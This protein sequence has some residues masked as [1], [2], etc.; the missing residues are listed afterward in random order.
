MKSW[1]AVAVLALASSL[2]AQA[3]VQWES[4]GLPYVMPPK[5]NP[6]VSDPDRGVEMIKERQVQ[7]RGLTMEF[8]RIGHVEIEVFNNT[9]DVPQTEAWVEVDEIRVISGFAKVTRSKGLR[10]FYIQGNGPVVLDVL[11]RVS[12]KTDASALDIKVTSPYR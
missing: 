12:T 6:S 11:T 2:S 4:D 10:S 9:R 7:L 3:H 1:I 5:H 8:K